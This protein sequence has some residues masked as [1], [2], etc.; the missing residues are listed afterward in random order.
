MPIGISHDTRNQVIR[1]W[2]AG[3]PR[4]K[5]ASDTELAAG[6][7]TNIVRD[8]RHELGYPTADALRQLAIDLKRLGISTV[9]CAIGFRIVN[10]IKRLGLVEADEEKRL[11]SFVSDIYNKCKYYGLMPDK[12]VTLAMQILDLL[13]SIP[14]SQIP[15]YVEEKSKDKQKLE[16]EIK[17][18]LER[19]SSTQLEYEEALR[20]KKVT[21]D[22]LQEFTHMQDTLIEYDLSIEDT[23]NLVNALKNAQ[24]LGYDAN[25][26]ADKISTIESLEEREKELK[27]NLM[28]L[29][30]ELRML[31]HA[32][33]LH[34]QKI[35]KYQ[36]I[37]VE[38]DKLQN[39]GFG[40]REFI[41]LNNTV[42]EI[43]TSNNI[44]PSIAVKKFFQDIVERNALTKTVDELRQEKKRMDILIDS[45]FNNA[46][47]FIESFGQEAK[48]DIA[49]IS[50]I[51][52]QN[53][54]AIQIQT[55]Q[56]VKEADTII[57]SLNTEV[58]TQFEEIQKLGSCPE[59][60]ALIR[61]A[62][63]DNSVNLEELK[64]A[65][66]KTIDIIMSRL[67]DDDDNNNNREIKESLER[68]RISLQS[69]SS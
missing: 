13:E 9:D 2:L 45:Q 1:E 33:F 24:Q 17:N 68:A 28:K 62:K 6:T 47:I 27:N 50:S 65:G 29:Q 43:A 36:R 58:K 66:I 53:L 59:F 57:K 44:D 10:I 61:A 34:D 67:S 8:W 51:T 21:I 5:I 63:G 38:Y 69:K 41:L 23:P 48:K 7:I 18:L 31:K 12:L 3:E 26:I 42:R 11:E 14:L 54:Q 56:T 49:D 32:I 4:D 60:S 16:E 15:N 40:L 35:D 64:Y 30:D 39:I 25:A 52:T 20:K 37:L 55:L 19:K 46:R 22:M